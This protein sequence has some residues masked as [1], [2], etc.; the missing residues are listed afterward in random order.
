MAVVQPFW[1]LRY[2]ERKAGP[3]EALVA[4]P[5]DVIGPDERERLLA[6]S[7]YNVV[8]LTLPDD[9]REAARRFADWRRDGVLVAEE[10]PRYWVLAQEYA[11]PDGVSRTRTGVV[12]SLRVEPYETRAILPHERTHEGPKADRL[13]LLR[14]V[15]AQLEPIL[16]LYD[17][18]P[19]VATPDRPPDLEAAGARLWRVD[20]SPEI[21]RAFR[22][23]RLLIADGHHRYETA[24]AFHEEE[25][26]PA[27]AFTM[28]V[29]VSTRDPGLMIFPTHRIVERLEADLPAVRD[30]DARA[31]LRRL[32]QH[33]GEAAA[34]V[35]YAKGRAGTLQGGVGELDTELVE[36]HRPQGVSY[37]AY[38]DEAIAA[39][40]SGRAQA[41][42]LL[43]PTRIEQVFAVAE[44]GETMPQKSTYF[45]PKLLSGLLFHPV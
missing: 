36:R 2:D 32:E 19:P 34:A 1:A 4:P 37:T 3:L 31:A 24:V 13:R 26:T 38:E 33:G 30:G 25:G 8:H 23:R 29:L 10:L 44:R 9:E 15:Q 45:Y 22:D 35:V 43:R 14:A 7:P 20:P 16:L 18:E 6:R 11:G 42:F 27:S 41:A 12:V 17:A 40:D 28:A 21:E 5:Y 39:V